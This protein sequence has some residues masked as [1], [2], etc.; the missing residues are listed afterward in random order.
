VGAPLLGNIKRRTGLRE[1]RV[2]S[3][4]DRITTFPYHLPEKF[5]QDFKMGK[6]GYGTYQFLATFA[7]PYGC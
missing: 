5:T 2:S 4:D 1:I 6:H 7:S 3:V